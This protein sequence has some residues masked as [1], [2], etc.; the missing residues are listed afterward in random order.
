MRDMRVLYLTGFYPPPETANGIRAFYF[1]RELVNEGFDVVVVETVSRSN[2]DVGGF[3]GE[4]VV[5]IPLKSKGV[6]KRSFDILYKVLAV[7]KALSKLCMRYKPDI[8][9]ASWPS[10]DAM[11]LGGRLSEE[12]KIPLVVDVQDLSDY[13]SMMT[14]KYSVILRSLLYDK[15]YDIIDRA[16]NIATVTEPFKKLLE[17]RVGR[18]DIFLIYNGVDVDL[19]KKEL[20]NLNYRSK[21]VGGE[22][23]GV[24]A[25]DLNWKYHMLDRF[26]IAIAIM[27][28]KYRKRL[29]FEVIGSGRLLKYYEDVVKVLG[30]DNVVTFVG[31]LERGEFIRRLILA[32]FGVI[33]RPNINNLWNIASVRTTLYEYMAAGLPIF[34]FGPPTSYIKHLIIKHKLGLYVSTDNPIILADELC[35]FLNNLD[36]FNRR[37][38]HEAS[39][40]YYWGTLSKEFALIVKRSIK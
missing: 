32:D 37:E 9:I 2:V 13:Y 25:G 6:I 23:V 5:R 33:G 16:T 24:F 7:G 36:S 8:I 26:L 10:H 30:I 4:K 28:K 15:I 27:M 40:R 12:L 34:A 29:R 20:D 21:S 14:D 31:Y 22:I 39:Y 19:Y 38:I 11:L 3:F 17:L 18:K 35:N 1:V